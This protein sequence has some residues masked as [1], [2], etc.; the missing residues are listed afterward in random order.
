MS[1]F[2]NIP[3]GA[4]NGS[5][6]I[7]P[8]TFDPSLFALTDEQRAAMLSVVGAS[9]VDA[10]FHHIPPHYALSERLNLPDA[11]SE[12]TL[13]RLMRARAEE[14]L[15]CQDAVCFLGG[16]VYDHHVPSVVDSIAARG[17][18][19]TAYTPYQPEMSQ[20]LLGALETFTRKIA[21]ATGLPVVPS[22]HYD[23]ATALA[24]ACWMAV[25]ATG[26]KRVAVSSFLLP[27]YRDVL[28]TYCWGR[29]VEIVLIGTDH[30]AAQIDSTIA[31]LVVQTPNALGVIED[32]GALIHSAHASGALSIGLQH[33]WL[34]FFLG[35]QATAGFDI[36]VMEGQPL[37]LHMYAGGAHLGVLACRADLRR[38]TPGRLIGT[39]HSS[40]W[41]RSILALVDEERE[42][43]VAR[44]C[45]TS[46]ICSNQA[47]QALR[48]GVF[49]GLYGATGVAKL[50]AMSHHNA[51]ALRA[52]LCAL[53]GVTCPYSGPIF[54]EFAVRFESEEVCTR[55]VA[56]LRAMNVFAGLSKKEHELLAENDLLIALT[57]KREP[58]ELRAYVTGVAG[59]LGVT[60]DPALAVLGIEVARPWTPRETALIKHAELQPTPEIV[61]V[62]NYNALCRTSFGVDTGSYPL[63]SCTMKYSPKRNDAIA[64]QPGFQALHPLQPRETL[65]GLTTIYRELKTYIAKIVGMDGVDLTPAAGA[66]GELK[67]L[68]IARRYF[69]DLG[70]AHRTEVVIPDNA[71]GTNPATA[72]MVG[73]RC[74]IVPTLPNGMI[75]L[76]AVRKVLSDKTAVLMTT[77]PSTFGIFEE[78]IGELVAMAHGVGAL[79]YYD[80]ANMNALMGRTTPGLMGFDMAHVNVHK[81]LSTPHGGGGP[82]AG[83]IGVKEPLVRYLSPGLEAPGVGGP[84]PIK[85]YHGHISVLL[86]SYAYIRSLGPTG[87][88]EAAGDAVLNANYLMRRLEHVIP[89]VF[90]RT[91][92]HEFLLDGRSLPIPA[93]DLAKRMIAYNVHPPTLVGAGCVFYQT[94]L[95]QAM[96]FEPTE[97]ETKADLDRLV[98]IITK[99]VREER[100]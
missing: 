8:R 75:D 18:F 56:Q 100:V 58:A 10:L 70:Q 85:L 84:L 21:A 54:H 1:D 83:P 43:H 25:S 12:W 86:R 90:N 51:L 45:A 26:R 36:V 76:D 50:A 24:E 79:V 68:L 65:G 5:P 57:E 80:G 81:T 16:G 4:N 13:K 23:G 97:T 61:L 15:N 94:D 53:P 40:I 7:G 60:P 17:E 19:L 55:V 11:S 95:T 87:L 41:G 78:R 42:Q 47:L 44:H 73:Y 14:N 66:H 35:E 63:G 33:A 92:M 88:R 72:T 3:L 71:H 28:A 27:Q 34:P 82:G 46:N 22:G 39:K 67:G 93:L 6:S 9:S 32:Y 38:W 29:S 52:A 74:R 59:A 62:R 69:E 98:D 31:A 49:L 99:I 48:A 20:G 30:H 37:G 2:D 77:N 89:P 96:L 64:E 91:C